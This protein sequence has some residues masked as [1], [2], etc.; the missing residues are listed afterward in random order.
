MIL[1]RSRQELGDRLRS[2]HLSMR[3]VE[4]MFRALPLALTT[5][6]GSVHADSAC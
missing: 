4:R 2:L 5:A 3:R 1:V 6:L